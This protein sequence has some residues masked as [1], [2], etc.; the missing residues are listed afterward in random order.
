[1]P[2]FPMQKKSTQACCFKSNTK[3][4]RPLM[5]KTLISKT[6]NLHKSKF[7]KIKKSR[8]GAR[9][10][11]STMT[12][13]NRK[14]LIPIPSA[15]QRSNMQQFPKA[16]NA[17]SRH[18]WHPNLQNFRN[19][20]RPDFQYRSFPKAIGQHQKIP[21]P[22]NPKSPRCPNTKKSKTAKVRY[23]ET[24]T[25]KIPES[26]ESFC[27][28]QN[29][30]LVLGGK[31]AWPNQQREVEGEANGNKEKAEEGKPRGKQNKMKGMNLRQ[32]HCVPS[33]CA[34]PPKWSQNVHAKTCIDRCR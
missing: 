22:I 13:P 9:C 26:N 32:G 14:H 17:K 4:K 25:F 15:Q 6:W 18:S 29:C 23:E 21:K 34:W 30:Q 11:A 27:V 24:P 3:P 31:T 5:Q 1:M 12:Q 28:Y 16:L 33:H 2:K 8:H 10:Q 7:P 19:T 20:K